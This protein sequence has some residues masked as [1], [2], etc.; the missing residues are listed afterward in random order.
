MKFSAGHVWVKDVQSCTVQLGISDFAQKEF[1][2]VVFV[3]LPAM[4]TYLRIGAP[5]S[6]IESVKT[7]TELL[8]PVEGR[9]IRVNEAI[10]ATP[11]LINQSA[12]DKGWFIEIELEEESPDLMTLEQYGASVQA[13]E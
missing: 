11:G 2:D 5:F 8:S 10:V 6:N 1:G 7:V 3:E 9:V 13:G 4:G 12:E